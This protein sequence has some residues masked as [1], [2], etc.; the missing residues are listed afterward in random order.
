MTTTRIST[1]P[2][3]LAEE[4]HAKGC[5]ATRVERFSS[6]KPPRASGFPATPMVTTRCIEC[7]A[8]SVAPDPDEAA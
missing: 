7:G 4:F 5:P 3:E 1:P 2:I 6:T 8:Q